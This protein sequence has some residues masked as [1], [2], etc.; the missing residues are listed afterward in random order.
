L[1]RERPIGAPLCSFEPLCHPPPTAMAP[2]S[3]YCLVASSSRIGPDGLP[4]FEE[5]RSR[6][7]AYTAIRLS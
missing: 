7:A 5:L 3:L 6:E 2:A 1:L 4:R